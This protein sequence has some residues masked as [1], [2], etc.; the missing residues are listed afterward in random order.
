MYVE[1]RARMLAHNQPNL[2][3]AVLKIGV[4]KNFCLESMHYIKKFHNSLILSFSDIYNL[5]IC[6]TVNL[7][8]AFCCNAVRTIRYHQ[9]TEQL[10]APVQTG[11]NDV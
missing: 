6:L 10:I 5:L 9:Q 3:W 1:T 7:R 2:S 11:L 8:I 4:A